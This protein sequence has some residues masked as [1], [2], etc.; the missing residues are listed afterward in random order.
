MHIS[1]S[2]FTTTVY[3]ENKRSVFIK[4]CL[5]NNALRKT[6]FVRMHVTANSL[7]FFISYSL[8][9]VSLILEMFNFY[10]W[11]YTYFGAIDKNDDSE[12]SLIM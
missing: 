6:L 4:V 8:Y 2:F 5:D 9:L 10:I 3:A 7:K 12:F 1:V 11:N